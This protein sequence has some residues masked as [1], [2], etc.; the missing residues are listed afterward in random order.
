M[1]RLTQFSHG[2]GCG[3]KLS[4]AVLRQILAQVTPGERPPELL[5]GHDTRDDAAV[6]DL[7]DGSA[8]VSTTDFFMPIVDDPRDFGRI[9][10]TNAIS[11]VYAVGGRPLLAIAILG[12]PIERLPP[13]VAGQ[14]VE[15]GRE[16]CAAAGIPLA[17]GHSID[18][19]E[20]IFGLAVSGRVQLEHLKRNSS[21]TPGCELWLTKA[22]GVGIL[23]T[24]EK[25]GRLREEHRGAALEVM[26]TLNR[27]GARLGA[28]PG[29]R[30]MTDVTGFGLLGHLVELCEESDVRASL[31]ASAVPTLPGVADYLAGGCVPG[32]AR[33]NWESYGE[34]V[35]LEAGEREL[36]CDPQTS[37]GLLVALE[38]AAREAFLEACAAEGVRPSQVGATLEPEPGAPRVVVA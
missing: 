14:V 15:G 17:G 29:V 13:E 8:L 4:P 6:V 28:L 38:P 9:A 7:G 10:A 32:G 18:A 26:T 36:L 1:T 21:A 12:W 2:A 25:R 20:P 30:A 27:V 35:L 3:C 33:R 5:V 22:L 31:Q 11:D 23:S 19:P 34:Q 16:V 37:G 24:A